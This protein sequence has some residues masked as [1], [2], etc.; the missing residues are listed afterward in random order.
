MVDWVGECVVFGLV[1][2][3]VQ[4]VFVAATVLEALPGGGRCVVGCVHGCRVLVLSKTQLA[5]GA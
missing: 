3:A 2:A 5:S 1:A 4:Y